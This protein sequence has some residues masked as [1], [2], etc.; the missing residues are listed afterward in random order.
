MNYHPDDFM[1]LTATVE[2]EGGS[3]LRDKCKGRKVVYALPEGSR[4]TMFTAGCGLHAR[5][6]VP[7]DP[8]QPIDIETYANI[9]REVDGRTEEVRV[10]TRI[11][12]D[13]EAAKA[14]FVPVCAVDDAMGAWPRYANLCPKSILNS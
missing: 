11:K 6:A 4:T 7:Y 8:T 14:S 13:G 2:S 1:A 10:R 3:I 12:N 5:F 9:D